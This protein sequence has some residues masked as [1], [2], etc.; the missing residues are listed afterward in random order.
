M[1]RPL[2]VYPAKPSGSDLTAL[3]AAKAMI[4]TDILIQPVRAVPGSPGRILAFREKPNFACDYAL[5]K[6]PT[7]QEIKP[8]LEWALGLNDY[9]QGVGTIALLR[10]VFGPEVE[11]ITNGQEM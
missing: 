8:A 10:E 9:Y 11:E 5:I 7:P 6:E 3:K 4:K 1:T 2:P